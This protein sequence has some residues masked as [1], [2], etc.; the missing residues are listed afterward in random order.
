MSSAS[1]TGDLQPLAP[2]LL[3]P[4]TA[5]APWRFAFFRRTPGDETEISYTVESSGTLATGSWTTENGAPEIITPGEQWQ[6]VA[7]PLAQPPGNA[8]NPRFFRLKLGV[9]P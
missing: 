5:G 6:Q 7:V 4:A 2:R 9:I 1:R 8:A 3:P